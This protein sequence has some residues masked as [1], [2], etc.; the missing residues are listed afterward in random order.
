MVRYIHF[1]ARCFIA[2][3]LFY[4]KKKICFGSLLHCQTCYFPAIGRIHLGCSS[5]ASK[6]NI[7]QSNTHCDTVA[8]SYHWHV[9]CAVMVSF[10]NWASNVLDFVSPECFLQLSHNVF[11]VQW[12]QLLYIC[13]TQWCWQSTRSITFYP[14]IN[15]IW[16]SRV[17]FFLLLFLPLFPLVN[18]SAAVIRSE[19]FPHAGLSHVGHRVYS[20]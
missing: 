5:F 1:A 14:L 20:K 13:R 19:Y 7:F 16:H 12:L 11:F 15:L 3:H 10:T 18:S 9:N 2:F 17:I 4:Y 8:V 6:F